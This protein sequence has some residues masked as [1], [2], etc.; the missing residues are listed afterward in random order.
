MAQLL[1]ASVI[2]G[3]LVG[4]VVAGFDYLVEDV[5]LHRVFSLPLYVQAVLPVIGLTT[6][7]VLLKV[8]GSKDVTPA[9]SDEYI[10]A[11]HDR[12]PTLKLRNLPAKLLAGISTIGMGGALGLEGPSLYTGASIGINSSRLIKWFRREERKMLLVAG[13]AAGVAA[14]FKAPATGVIFALEAPYRDDTTRRALL[15]SLIAAAVGYLVFILAADTSA[16]FQNL[17]QVP[18]ELRTRDLLGGAAVGLAAGLGG[19]F[20]GWLVRF[21]KRLAETTSIYWR[22]AVGGAILAGLVVLCDWIFASPLSLGPGQAAVEWAIDPD[23]GLGFII[24][25][26]GIRLGATLTTV[27]MGGTG[28]LFIPLVTQ[29]IIMGAVIGDLLGENETSLYPILGLAAFLGAGYRVPIAAVVFVAET[30]LGSPFVVPALVASAI[31]QLVAGRSSV[32]NYQLSERLGHLENRLTL[33]ISSA[34]TT[35]ILTVPPDALVSEFIYNHVLGNRQR[36]VPVLKDG[37]Y[38]GMCRWEVAAEIE[39]EKW[40]TTTIAEIISEDFPTGRLSWKLRDAVVAMEAA[41]TETLAVI[42]PDGTFSG[43]V[44]EADIIRLKEILDE[45]PDEQN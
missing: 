17:G 3:A 34:L 29:G 9:T 2:L 36:E 31:S 33:P 13:A 14:I 45:T 38:L 6:A 28:G 43:V 26:F 19:R 15:P 35:D 40:D 10:K 18:D 37:I 42:A 8:I 30:T 44:Y 24:L 11:F 41:D 1:L 25:L 27:S 12:S 21:A 4:I 32:A 5:I 23:R 20:Y 22:I 39:R 7:A 16:I